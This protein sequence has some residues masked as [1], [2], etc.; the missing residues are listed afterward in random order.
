M[1][2]LIIL[3]AIVI[4]ALAWFLR[5]GGDD[6]V[7]VQ[8][9]IV[10]RMPL[11]SIVSGSGQVR[12]KISVDISSDVM[13]RVRQVLVEEGDS[14]EKK[15]V[16]AKIDSSQLEAKIRGLKAG[17]DSARAGLV[18]ARTSMNR[19]QK[20]LERQTEMHRKKLVSDSDYE[21]AAS[22]KE[23]AIAAESV[24][25]ARLAQAQAHLEEA[26]D[27]LRRYTILSPMKGIITRKNI[28]AGEMA[29]T[30]TLNTPGTLLLTVSD[31]SVMEVEIEIDEIDVVHVQK[32]QRAE[33]TVDAYPDR[34]W[35]GSVTEVGTSAL[36]KLGQKSRDFRVVITLETPAS[37]LKPGLSASADI[38]TAVK[39]SA[40]AI[41]LQA[42]TVRTLENADEK[43][44]NPSAVPAASRTGG[45]RPGARFRSQEREGIFRVVD[46]VARFVPVK[47][48]I[49]GE[50]HFEVVDGLK[51]HQIVVVGPYE[52]LRTLRSGQKVKD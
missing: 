14:V 29:V 38:T 36:Q 4:A 24:A 31:L 7:A 51:E 52:A 50:T 23:D 19:A 16:L 46:E 5:R 35:L 15:Q 11:R 17:A 41:P 28:E 47:L 13:G 44:E 45:W 25:R 49:V 21:L 26:E 20:S 40:L 42:L 43:K 33:V 18:Q 39:K 32:K 37:E 34:L 27:T 3:A 22:V 48:G 30:G 9:E 10:Q 6:V 8:T 12:P 1:K 2:K